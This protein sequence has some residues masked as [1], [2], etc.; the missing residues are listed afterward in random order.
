MRIANAES[1]RRYDA[2]FLGKLYGK[3]SITTCCSRDL[4]FARKYDRGRRCDLEGGAFGRGV[5]TASRG[6]HEA[7][8]LRVAT[9]NATA[10]RASA[11]VRNVKEQCVG[12]EGSCDRTATLDKKSSSSTARRTKRISE[13]MRFRCFS[14][15]AH[16]A[17]AARKVPL[18]IYRR[19]EG[20][21]SAGAM[22]NIVNVGAAFDA[23]AISEYDRCRVV[24]RLLLR[25]ALHV[26]VSHA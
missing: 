1:K 22:M 4:R 9:K 11:K 16:A 23:D 21:R 6:E 20:K 7:W 5:Q 25:S 12:A 19:R 10:A 24:H 14:F 8:E 15:Y 3:T 17:A 18:S 26:E 2:Q 13:R